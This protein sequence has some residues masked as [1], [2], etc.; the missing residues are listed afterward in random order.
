MIKTKE[1]GNGQFQKGKEMNIIQREKR[2]QKVT[3]NVSKLAWK[4]QEILAIQLVS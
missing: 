4:K 1:I 2:C 3:W